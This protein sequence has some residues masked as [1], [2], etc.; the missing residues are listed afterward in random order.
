[1]SPFRTSTLDSIINIL[2]D[3]EDLKL[4][5]HAEFALGKTVRVSSKDQR[6]ATSSE[7]KRSRRVDRAS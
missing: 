5:R 3:E 4:R 7:T 1:M 6:S 2:V